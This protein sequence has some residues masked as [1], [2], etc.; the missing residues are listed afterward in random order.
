MAMDDF[1]E[2]SKTELSQMIESY[3]SKY[4]TLG[5]YYSDEYDFLQDIEDIGKEKIKV[6]SERR[7]RPGRPKKTEMIKKFL[8]RT[9]LQ[10]RRDDEFDEA[11][12]ER[13]QLEGKIG[14]WANRGRKKKRGRPKR[15]EYYQN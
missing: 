13:L 12:L 3:V 9:I 8:K 5:L 10:P 4:L 14:N 11:E 15:E 1:E 6:M 2:D 7:G